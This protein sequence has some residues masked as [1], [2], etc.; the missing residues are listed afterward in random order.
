MPTPLD[1]EDINAKGGHCAS[2]DDSLS[3]CIYD[4]LLPLSKMPM[5]TY[6][7]D[8]Q[9]SSHDLLKNKLAPV[10]DLDN[11]RYCRACQCTLP[12]SSFPS[13]TRRY[14][15]K[16]HIWERIQGPSKRRALANN[17]HKRKLWTLWKKCWND[18]KR[19]FNQD[20]ILLLQRDIE[21]TLAQLEG[22]SHNG[23]H[24]GA[25]SQ[26]ELIHQSEG[27]SHNGCHNGEE[28]IHPSEGSSHDCHDNGSPSQHELIR[29]STADASDRNPPADPTTEKDRES[30]IIR[31]IAL[32]PS[33]PQHPLSRDN[34]VVVDRH[35][36]RVLLEAFRRGGPSKYVSELGA[37]E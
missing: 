14:L 12:L 15:C 6:T 22:S 35:A 37:M 27:S 34:V 26:L 1:N 19:T 23:C 29:D 20:R 9:A 24:N 28:L 17:S 31:D 25:P 18:A 11:R 30:D 7:Q 36:R 16:R 10:P 32:M 4:G 3:R 21:E 2:I 13:G 5:T 33:D 8:T